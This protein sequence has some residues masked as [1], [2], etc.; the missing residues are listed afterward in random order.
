METPVVQVMDCPVIANLVIPV[1]CEINETVYAPLVDS[2]P[3]NQWVPCAAYDIGSGAT[4]FMGAMVDVNT[5]HIAQ[6]FYSGSI[7]VAYRQ[8]LIDS[9]S[10]DFSDLIQDMGLNAL[11]SAKSAIEQA[12]QQAGLQDYGDIQH[13]AVATAAFREAD[14]GFI[15]ANQFEQMLD[16]SIDILSQEDEGK[17][18][19]HGAV[20]QADLEQS[21]PVVWDIGGGSLQLTYKDAGDYFHV[22]QGKLASA[23]FLDLVNENLAVNTDLYPMT[24]DSVQAAIDL[25]KTHL[26]FDQTTTEIVKQQIINDAPVL[27]VGS[28]HNFIVKPI[29]DLAGLSDKTHFNKQDI[30]QA[31]ELLTNKTEDQIMHMTNES[32]PDFVKNKLTNLILVYSLMDKMEIPEIQVVAVSNVQGL[33][34]QKAKPHQVEPFIFM[35]DKKDRMLFSEAIGAA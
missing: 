17:L 5:H 19:Y 35:P 13:F 8:D 3:S 10:N 21:L 4:K 2:Q 23:T 29:C 33:L 24:Q 12:Y 15:V 14:N 32:N 9:G 18:A 31:I 26:V 11:F 16:F 28:I 20:A 34:V 6:V 22:M 1:T 27:A 25:A 30:Y 7:P